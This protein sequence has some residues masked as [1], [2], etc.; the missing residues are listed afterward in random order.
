M[1]LDTTTIDTEEL[2]RRCKV[3]NLPPT[4]RLQAAPGGN[5]CFLDPP[6][7]PTYFTRC[8]YTR[9]GNSPTRGPDMLL[10]GRAL[11]EYTVGG[12]TRKAL[13]RAIY[14]PLPIDHPRVVEWMGN[15]FRHLADCYRIPKKLGRH[16]GD[17]TMVWPLPYY[18]LETFADDLQFSDE[19]R[20]RGRAEVEV[21]NKARTE[22]LRPYSGVGH[23][24]A[25]IAIR[26]V[27]P[28]FSDEAAEAM[29]AAKSKLLS[30][31]WGRHDVP[32]LPGQCPGDRGV[33]LTHKDEHCQFCG[34]HGNL[35]PA[36][37]TE[38]QEG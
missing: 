25:V 18:E 24:L 36:T 30:N 32:P 29:I 13:W 27:Y 28:D 2:A 12:E 9:H 11:P 14:R 16:A 19:W 3:Y 8:V 33:G 15:L 37:N 10:F 35:P 5:G 34:G 38:S 22:Q 7:Y 20:T 6:G 1:K 31:W 26:E 4:Y 21:R 17:T 23:H